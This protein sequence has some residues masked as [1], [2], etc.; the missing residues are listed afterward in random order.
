MLAIL[1]A[2]VFGGVSTH[3]IEHTNNYCDCKRDGF[4]GAYCQ[5]FKV[6]ETDSCHK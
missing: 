6:S 5:T 4:K 3:L 1:I 2:M